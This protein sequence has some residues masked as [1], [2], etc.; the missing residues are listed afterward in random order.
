MTN[1]T[2]TAQQPTS[3]ANTGI[4]I[5]KTL[6]GNNKVESLIVD[7]GPLIK[8]HQLVH[9]A[10]SFYTV[11]EVLDEIKDQNTRDMVASLPFDLVVRNPSSEA[12]AAV[13]AFS[14]KTGD[15][16]SMS[17]TDMK[18][19]ALTWMIEKETNGLSHIRS[20]PLHAMT[21]NGTNNDAKPVP[22]PALQKTQNIAVDQN[23]EPLVEA[24]KSKSSD[25]VTKTNS[26]KKQAKVAAE[27][28]DDAGW[29]T[30][31]NIAKH[32]AKDLYG[33]ISVKNAA[34]APSVAC[35]TTDFAMQN[36]LLQM[37]LNVLSVDGITVRKLRSWVLRCHSCYKVTKDMN[38]QFCPSCGNST[39]NRVSVGIN[40]NGQTI[41]YLKKNFQVN[42]RGTRYSIPKPKTGRNANNL[43]VCEDQKEY[44][45]ALQQK[46][47]RDKQLLNQD[48]MSLDSAILGSIG[49]KNSD[50]G[51]SLLTKS[52]MP[53]VGYGHRNVNASRGRRRK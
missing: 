6:N 28:D 1:E 37:N 36:V 13:A 11:R 22:K 12:V 52:G 24:V 53:L 27:M 15:Y 40:A 30:P 46:Q 51:P 5:K 31:Q 23:V 9:L 10:N 4:K 16:T 49:H 42:L 29:I 21:S 14:K 38:K 34:K 45:R 17:T 48:S 19:L 44:Q 26:K 25:N 18:I 2:T 47:R 33:S 20:Q 7:S 8:G 50:G 35:M 32:K 3:N 43:I 41:Y 39:L